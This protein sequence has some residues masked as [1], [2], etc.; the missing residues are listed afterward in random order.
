MITRV[1][2]VFGA[3]DIGAENTMIRSINYYGV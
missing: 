2:V 1:I 3:V